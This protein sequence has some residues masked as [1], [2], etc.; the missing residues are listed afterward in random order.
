MLRYLQKNPFSSLL[1]CT[2]HLTDVHLKT[3]KTIKPLTMH[4]IFSKASTQTS[5]EDIVTRQGNGGQ[6]GN[7][8]TRATGYI[9][10]ADWVEI[11]LPISSPGLPKIGG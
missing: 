4:L 7:S 10:C 8:S 2:E 5:R 11:V 9:L 3:A 6:V 1:V